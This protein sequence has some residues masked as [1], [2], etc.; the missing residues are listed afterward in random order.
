MNSTKSQKP[1]IYKPRIGDDAYHI[2]AQAYRSQQN[3]LQQSTSTPYNFGTDPRWASPSNASPVATTYS[4]TTLY[5][6]TAS[7][8]KFS[9]TSKS[10]AQSTGVLA[11]PAHFRHPYPPPMPPSKQSN[12]LSGRAPSSKPNPFAKYSYLQKEHNRSPLAYKSP[13][14]PGGGFMNGY[15]GSLEKHLQQTLFHGRTTTATPSFSSNERVYPNQP[16]PSPSYGHTPQ[17]VSGPY[18]VGTVQKQAALPPQ[19]ITK[20]VVQNIWDN[21]EPKLHHAIRPEYSSAMQNQFQPSRHPAASHQPQST[22]PQSPYDRQ[23]QH[24]QESTQTAHVQQLPKVQ[25]STQ[26]LPPTTHALHDSVR[27][28]VNLPVSQ[29]Q[30]RD[31]SAV[32]H[33]SS[34]ALYPHQQYFQTS[35]SQGQL[36]NLQSQSWT[37]SPQSQIQDQTSQQRDLPDVPAD[38]TSLIERM[39]VNLKKAADSTSS[40]S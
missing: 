2:D 4:P 24:M 26:S 34:K 25:Q 8:P 33:H 18:G 31:L 20:P 35:H 27:Q 40:T 15:Q 3:F 37:Q 5:S 16:L 28:P 38:S 30:H 22:L 23:Q 12:P 11:P 29:P 6:P 9:T 10:T 21:K 32:S 36:S 17:P 19:Q 39:M 1:Y 14:R 7:Y 13:Y